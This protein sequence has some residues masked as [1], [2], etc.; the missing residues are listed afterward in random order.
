MFIF[1]TIVIFANALILTVLLQ[2]LTKGDE[3]LS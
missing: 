1:H 2:R 3:I